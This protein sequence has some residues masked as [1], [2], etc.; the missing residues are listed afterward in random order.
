[1]VLRESFQLLVDVQVWGL[2]VLLVYDALDCVGQGI[3]VRVVS[4]NCVVEQLSL[5]DD[6]LMLR[7]GGLGQLLVYR[8]AAVLAPA[9]WTIGGAFGLLMV[10][11]DI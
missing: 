10:H 7:Q 5:V 6:V 4:I 2:S 9:R 3:V 1:M 11:D 8:L